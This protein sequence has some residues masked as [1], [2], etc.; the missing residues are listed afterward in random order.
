MTAYAVRTPLVRANLHAVYDAAEAEC[1]LRAHERARGGGRHDRAEQKTDVESRWTQ[2]EVR[3][4]PTDQGY[5]RK[6]ATWEPCLPWGCRA[7]ATAY[8]RM[9]VGQSSYAD[10][11]ECARPARA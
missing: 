3:S 11:A 4:Q 5:H 7:A 2:K 6:V 9:A 10:K 8:S 1:G